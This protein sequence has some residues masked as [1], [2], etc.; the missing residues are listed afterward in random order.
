M[1]FFGKL[2]VCV[3][4]VVSLLFLAFAI[5]TYT[6]RID[7]FN[8]RPEGG[9][10]IKGKVSVLQA[11]LGDLIEAKSRAESRWTSTRT[12]LLALEVKRPE[13][14]DYYKANLILAETGQYKGQPVA[15]P[16]RALKIDANGEIIL[17][18][19]TDPAP[20]DR[21][22]IEIRPGTPLTSLSAY[23]QLIAGSHTDIKTVQEELKK[24]ID[25]QKELTNKIIDTDQKGLRTLIKEQMVIEQLAQDEIAY[26]QPFLTNR[27]AESML[28]LKR[29]DA[30]QARL[31]EL[32]EFYG[33]SSNR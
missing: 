12:E 19:P 20:N 27:R 28:L 31:T 32:R 33:V 4:V 16:I 3:N 22:L 24:L 30:L 8:R 7:W 29:R 21:P 18:G 9:E 26:L 15:N 5:G 25:E 2:I 17:A 6:Q 10:E 11:K 1:T 13:R 23:D 14:Q